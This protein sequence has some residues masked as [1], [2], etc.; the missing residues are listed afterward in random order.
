MWIIA[1]CLVTVL[2]LDQTKVH[3]NLMWVPDL[4]WEK[5]CWEMD[6]VKWSKEENLWIGISQMNP[7]VIPVGVTVTVDTHGETPVTG[8]GVTMTGEEETETR[9]IV[10]A[11]AMIVT[12][13]G[14]GIVTETGI[15]TAGVLDQDHA[16]EAAAETEIDI[17]ETDHQETIVLK[18][19]V[20]HP[21]LRLLRN[22][23]NDQPD[24]CISRTCH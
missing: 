17:A 18:L 21:G 23:M 5:V 15:V 4:G 10:I 11:V 3:H 1:Q 14:I 19:K 22:L 9:E 16:I 20:I 6:P 7:A 8:I 13:R 12:V 2:A 24:S